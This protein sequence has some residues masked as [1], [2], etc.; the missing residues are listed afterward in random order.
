MEASVGLPRQSRTVA[1]WCGL[2]VATS[3]FPYLKYFIN[4]MI[5]T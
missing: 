2:I 3:I 5:H 4:L 1:G